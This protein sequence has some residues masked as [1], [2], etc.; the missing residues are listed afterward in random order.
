MSHKSILSLFLV[1]SFCFSPSVAQ[2]PN[3]TSG[4]T[5]VGIVSSVYGD[6]HIKRKDSKDFADRAYWLSLLYPQDILETKDNSKIVVTYFH[7]R[8][9]WVLEPGAKARVE[10]D[11]LDSD[12]VFKDRIRAK[13]AAASEQSFE[14]PR[15]LLTPI[16]QASGLEAKKGDIAKEDVYLSAYVDTAVYPPEFHWAPNSLSNYKLLLYGM[17][18]EFLHSF[19]VE[20]E[21]F[22]YPAG[23]SAPFRMT[24]GQLYFWEVVDRDNNILVGKYPF[25]PMTQLHISEVERYRRLLNDSEQSTQVDLLLVLVRHRALDKYLHLLQ[26]MDKKDPGNPIIENALAQAYLQRGTPAHALQI[27]KTKAP[28]SIG[29]P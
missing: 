5:P 14:V 29:Q 6:A 22:S 25:S 8:A 20:G 12:D 15:S 10:H 27:L 24:K 23:A 3:A 19:P 28:S 18:G 4:P 17:S 16:S 9:K 7:D 11:R 26:E 13:P 1:F 21:D 2:E